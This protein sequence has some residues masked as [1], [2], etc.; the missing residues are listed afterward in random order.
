VVEVERVASTRSAHTDGYL[1]T[2]AERG[3]TTNI[4]DDPAADLY[5]PLEQSPSKLIEAARLADVY[6][7][8]VPSLVTVPFSAARAR[9]RLAVLADSIGPVTLLERV[10]CEAA[11]TLVDYPDLN[12]FFTRGR[13][14]KY[15]DIAVGFAVNAGRSLRVPVVRNTARLSQ[16]DVCRGV[17]DLTLRYFREELSM[18]DVSG[19]TF[20]VTDLSSVGVTYFVPVLNDRQAAILGLCAADA[21]G[22]QSLVLAFDHRMSDGMRAASFL[23]EVRERLES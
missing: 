4:T 12:G 1:A 19:G 6:R 20:T 13:G 14:W 18:Q 21:N 23:N 17:R 11:A 9:E 16:L 8:V 5:E 2:R 15:K 3:A 22:Q 10:V 7:A